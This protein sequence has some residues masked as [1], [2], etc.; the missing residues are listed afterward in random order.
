MVLV[1]DDTCDA[2]LKVRD[3]SP[4]V[5]LLPDT[6]PYLPIALDSPGMSPLLSGAMAKITVPV[7]ETEDVSFDAVTAELQINEQA[8]A[9]AA[10]RHRRA[11]RR[12]RRPVAA[13]PGHRQPVDREPASLSAPRQA[14]RLGR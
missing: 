1:P 2:G 7:G 8:E 5:D 9:P 4:G 14:R 13:G 10:V 3:V 6:A 11:R 12:V